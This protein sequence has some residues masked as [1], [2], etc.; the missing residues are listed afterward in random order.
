MRVKYQMV[1]LIMNSQIYL[2]IPGSGQS[3]VGSL[4]EGLAKDAIVQAA[5]AQP[6]PGNK[7]FGKI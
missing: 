4:L 5:C 6:R 1:Y 2:A 7:A 3:V